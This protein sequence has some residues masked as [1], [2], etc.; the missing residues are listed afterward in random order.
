MAQCLLG[1]GANPYLLNRFNEGIT[2]YF[3]QRWQEK[4][5]SQELPNNCPMWRR[6][7]YTVDERV[8]FESSIQVLGPFILTMLYFTAVQKDVYS[9]L[10]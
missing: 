6:G 5:E 10:W 2:P 7:G 8:S 1:H 4:S 9:P 3:R